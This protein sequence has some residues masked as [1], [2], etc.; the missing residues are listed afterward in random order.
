[1]SEPNNKLS[2]F[3]AKSKVQYV[4][5]EDDYNPSGF[6]V[7][8]SEEEAFWIPGP[9][10]R[11]DYRYLKANKQEVYERMR[12]E[13][14]ERDRA[15]FEERMR[16]D[17][18]RIN[19][20][21]EQARTEGRNH[22]RM[23]IPLYMLEDP[24]PEDSEAINEY[25]AQ[26]LSQFREQLDTVEAEEE[27]I[28][29]NECNNERCEWLDYATEAHQYVCRSDAREEKIDFTK[30]NEEQL[31]RHRRGHRAKLYKICARIRGELNP[32]MYGRRAAFPSCVVSEI[33][34]YYPSPT[35]EYIGFREE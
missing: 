10:S 14:E 17:R 11:E 23:A 13:R 22:V 26:G 8:Q 35:G 7:F 6:C 16:R 28:V 4:N 2:R 21:M 34:S 19:N 31:E 32:H 33:R 30:F 27:S 25:V 24:S 3:I 18:E 29:C 5:D 1:M 20:I 9:I 12:A 15:A